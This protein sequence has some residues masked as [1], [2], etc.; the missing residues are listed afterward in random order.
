MR[1][2]L[3]KISITLHSV[4]TLLV[5]VVSVLLVHPAAL[6]AT[7]DSRSVS[8]STAIPGAVSQHSFGSTIP[9]TAVIGSII[10]EYCSNSPLNENPCT[11]PVGLDVLGALLTSQSGNVGFTINLSASSANQLVLTRLP[12]PGLTTFSTYVFDNIINPSDSASIYVRVRTYSSTDA[13]GL[14]NDYGSV[15]FATVESL[16]VDA[17][18]PPHLTFCSGITVALNCTAANGFYIDLNELKRSTPNTGTSQYSGSSNDPGGYSVKI[19]GNT[20]TAGNNTIPALIN[21]SPSLPGTSQFGVNLRANTNPSVGEE[22]VGPGTAAPSPNYNVPNNF[23]F[24]SGSNLSSSSLSTEFNLFTISY[25]VNVSAN[26]E[27]G[28]YSATLTFMATAAF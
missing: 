20:M 23:M 3:H 19:L 6:A 10:F 15:A 18:V 14:F 8:I 24:Q 17:F 25:L 1:G 21:P 7:L 9:S 12:S 2:L 13:T 22:A 5:I 27:P 11:P 28:I 26:Q 16:N 4:Q